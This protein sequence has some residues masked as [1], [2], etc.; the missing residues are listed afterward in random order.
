M[1]AI[2]FKDSKKPSLSFKGKFENITLRGKS[3][4]SRIRVK[5]LQNITLFATQ[6]KSIFSFRVCERIEWMFEILFVRIE[7][8]SVN[9]SDLI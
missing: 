1:T 3:I 5:N 6:G 2:R 8:L 7:I 4:F 9:D